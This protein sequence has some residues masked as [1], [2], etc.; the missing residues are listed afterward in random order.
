MPPNRDRANDGF[1]F[2]QEW[3]AEPVHQERPGQ[4]RGRLLTDPRRPRETN[5]HAPGPLLATATASRLEEPSLRT[6]PW[7]FFCLLDGVLPESQRAE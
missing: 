1:S 2:S 7:S 3:N 4:L 6:A 5:P